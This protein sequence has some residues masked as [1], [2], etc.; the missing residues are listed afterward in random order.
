MEFLWAYLVF[1][2]GVGLVLIKINSKYEKKSF[3]KLII[4]LQREVKVKK[5]VGVLRFMFVLILFILLSPIS[6][7]L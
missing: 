6:F 3:L 1:A 2:L 7:L 5:D 4:D